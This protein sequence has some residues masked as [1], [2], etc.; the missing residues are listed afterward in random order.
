M[1]P[2]QAI[3]KP[4]DA[5]ADVYAVGLVLYELL[6]GKPPF[7]AE[8][9]GR[10]VM[11]ITATPPPPLPAVTPAGEALPAELSAVVLKCLEKDPEARFQSAAELAA[12]LK[13]FD[14]SA[15]TP[16]PKPVE[17][18]EAALAASVQKSRAPMI[19]V[20]VGVVLLIVGLV[21]LLR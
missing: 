18:D 10:L 6:A 2:E 14:G 9:F 20:A 3:G 16:K 1:A 11:Q 19:G 4:V 12:A 8:N 21:L 17:I 13:P 15:P 7:T 5:R